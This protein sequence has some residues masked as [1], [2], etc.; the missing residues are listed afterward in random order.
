MKSRTIKEN[1]NNASKAILKEFPFCVNRNQGTYTCI[2]QSYCGSHV[3]LFLLF[4]L[5]HELL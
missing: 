2:V 4:N 5:R 1:K 3:I